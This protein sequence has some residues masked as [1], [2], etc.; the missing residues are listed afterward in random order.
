[1]VQVRSAKPERSELR[2]RRAAEVFSVYSSISRLDFVREHYAARKMRS[3]RYTVCE[4]CGVNVQHVPAYCTH[5]APLP[6]LAMRRIMHTF[7]AA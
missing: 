1:M 7:Y 2:V 5:C 6:A 4:L 3:M